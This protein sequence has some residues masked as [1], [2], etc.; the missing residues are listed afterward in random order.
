MVAVEVTVG[1]GGQTRRRRADNGFGGK[2][3]GGRLRAVHFIRRRR[4]PNISYNNYDAS[5]IT[6]SII[7]AYGGGDG[8]GG[9]NKKTKRRPYCRHL[10]PPFLKRNFS[11]P[12]AFPTSTARARVSARP[13]R[14]HRA[15]FRSRYRFIYNDHQL[16]ADRRRPGT[17]H[18]G[19]HDD[20][21]RGRGRWRKPSPDLPTTTSGSFF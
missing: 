13:A 20:L 21:L 1:C 2:N 8:G 14:R 19:R 16:S 6:R 5:A 15:P 10:P 7:T 17:N 18:D 12:D 9:L 4:P 3:Y 11:P